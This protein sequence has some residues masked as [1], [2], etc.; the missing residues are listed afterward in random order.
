[1]G[2]LDKVKKTF[3]SKKEDVESHNNNDNDEITNKLEPT[4]EKII[5]KPTPNDK[6]RNFKYLDDLIH[7]GIKEI[8][9]DSDIVLGEGEESQYLEGIGLDVDDLVIDVN[10]H[11]IDANGK[12]RIF[13]CT[14]KNI[15]IKQCTLKN[16]FSDDKGGAIYNF[17]GELIIIKSTLNNN[18]AQ[19]DLVA[20]GTI[21]N[22]GELTISESTLSSNI[23]NA[24]GAIFNMSKLTI[25]SSTLNENTAVHDGG[26]IYNDEGKLTI[27][28]S[29][30]N[31]NVGNWGGAIKNN[32]ELSVSDSALMKNTAA[33]CGGI[34]NV[35]G[36]V[37]IFQSK[38][39]DN[40]GKVGS[41]AILNEEGSFKIINCE[42][43]DNTI[44]GSKDYEHFKNIIENSGYLQSVNTNFYNNQT[45]HIIVIGS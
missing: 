5:D 41:G 37:E 24:G 8:L 39:I 7:S 31:N 26:A 20:G 42:I 23:A 45:K 17:N 1:M 38:L 28:D 32:G 36:S 44:S 11:S 18:I 3:G 29:T 30:L 33:Y 6:I 2:F 43:S 27:I 19:G 34:Y 22:E 10:G 13:Y 14:G 35:R 4:N 12:T 25:T 21:Y 15:T 9:L 16:G 40:S